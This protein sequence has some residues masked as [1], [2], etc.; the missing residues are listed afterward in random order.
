MSDLAEKIAMPITMLVIGFFVA[1]CS[2]LI[3]KYQKIVGKKQEIYKV[4]GCP[5]VFTVVLK[6]GKML[7]IKTKNITFHFNQNENY[8]I[9][10]DVWENYEI[11]LT[12]SI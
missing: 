11:F 4:I 1:F 12:G 3:E 7:N 6:N 9:L 5:D 8:I 2:E 10:T